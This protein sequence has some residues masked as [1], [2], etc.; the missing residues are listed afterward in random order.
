LYLGSQKELKAVAARVGRDAT[1]L[2]CFLCNWLVETAD[3]EFVSVVTGTRLM[4]DV[5]LGD[6]ASIVRAVAKLAKVKGACAT[7]T[8]AGIDGVD[9]DEDADDDDPAADSFPV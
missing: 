9:D 4:G 5:P 2:D 3:D 8:V 1:A 6:E 7:F